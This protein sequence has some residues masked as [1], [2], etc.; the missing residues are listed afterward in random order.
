MPSSI[1]R[2]GGL[3][4]MLQYLDFF[5][6]HVQRTAL[7]ATANCC[8][9]VNTEG[10]PKVQEILPILRGVL[11]YPD[12]KLVE[13]ATLALIRCIESARYKPDWMERLLD[14]ETA[15][16]VT[17]LLAPSA[18][19][20]LLSSAVYAHLL[21]ALTSAAR[22]STKVCLSLYD[23]EIPASMYFI[24]AGVLP[25][26]HA[27]PLDATGISAAIM[28]N[29][30]ERPK[31]Q[32]E[33][34][35]A[36]ICELLPPLSKEGVFDPRNYSEKMVG[37]YSK[38]KAKLEEEHPDGGFTS[39][40]LDEAVQVGRRETAAAARDNAEAPTAGTSVPKTEGRNTSSILNGRPKSEE[41]YQQK[42]ELFNASSDKIAAFISSIM[43]TLVDVFSASA[44]AR[45]RSRVLTA[46]VKCLA[47]SS[48]EQ[49]QASLKNVSFASFLSSIISSRD[50]PSFVLG[51]LQM[52]EIL[53]DKLPVIYR[54]SFRREGVF[55]EICKLADEELS[56]KKKPEAE[57]SSKGATPQTRAEE[58]L[59][60]PLA[61][62]LGDIVNRLE[63]VRNL[64]RGGGAAG[65]SSKRTS[66]VPSNPQDAVIVRARVVRIKKDLDSIQEATD[67][68][69]TGVSI[70]SD[71]LAILKNPESDDCAGKALKDI[72]QLFLNQ[73]EPLSSFE[74]LQSGLLHGLMDYVSAQDQEGRRRKLMQALT[75]TVDSFGVTALD[76]FI[77]RLQESL[78]RMETFEVETASSGLDD[79]RRSPLTNLVRQLRIRLK[80]EDPKDI[81]RVYQD[82][83]VQVQAIAPVSAVSGYLRQKVANA[84]NVGARG[85][86]GGALSSMFAALAGGEPPAAAKASSK[87]EAP[88]KAEEK[89]KLPRRRSSAR[90]RGEPVDAES[91]AAG[92]AAPKVNADEDED[93][94]EDGGAV[95]IGEME[96]EFDEDEDFSDEEEIIY[97]GALEDDDDEEAEIDRPV[98]QTVDLSAPPDDSAKPQATTPQGTRVATPTPTG[99]AADQSR[100]NDLPPKLGSYA[101]AV[102]TAPSDWHF[103]FKVGDQVLHGYD[104]IY[105]ALHRALRSEPSRAGGLERQNIWIM[106]PTIKFS[107]VQGPEP[108]PP[109]QPTE[110]VESDAA[111][112]SALP[113]SLPAES[114]QAIVLRMLRVLHSAAKGADE[115]MFIN[116]KLTAKFIRQ[117]EEL[118]IVA[119]D[120]L[121]DWAIDLPTH[122]PF[123]FPFE[124]RYTF[125]QSTSFGYSRLIGKWLAQQNPNDNQRRSGI[126]DTLPRPTRARVRIIRPKILESASRVMELYGP[127]AGILEI[128]YQD[129]PGTGLGPTLEFYTLVSKAFAERKLELWRDEDTSAQGDYVFHPHGLFPRPLSPDQPLQ[130]P[131]KS[132]QPY[133]KTLGTFV[134][135]ALLDSRIIDL[136]FNPLLMSAML[137]HKIPL[138]IDSLKVSHL[139]G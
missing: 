17:N 5:S 3:Q 139:S 8:R 108:L 125:L 51:A 15:L 19:S 82:M 46:L 40:M 83:V 13:Q 10:F 123:L 118:V 42:M 34:A 75:E 113:P 50:D 69:S 28:Q 30:G 53:L 127:S 138:T 55:F 122:F 71:A 39:Q 31:E 68:A 64:V 23:A 29:M 61:S 26:S 63:E 18:G 114:P 116:P 89:D 45:I 2:E 27:D 104:T 132:E 57:T 1:V 99:S 107:K 72:A 77:K 6:T 56:S 105:G 66:S 65:S 95:V 88:P 12:Q 101:A 37:R 35:L 38:A 48:S 74:L 4:A 110:V 22:S 86:A 41:T 24:L 14:T 106:Q 126:L 103:Q 47:Y 25:S 16:A 120:C 91:S 54:R 98:E 90:L 93:A 79:S 21:R 76:V 58:I 43:P 96:G 32:I 128:E 111:D 44:A 135:K 33:E 131:Q 94:D 78:S 119:S 59:A 117:L 67:F 81:P 20:T 109:C 124:A 137:G 115:S 70:I 36:C 49:L 85:G 87:S 11:A 100:S 112:A 134:G 62:D 102:K 80:A 121:P 133:F 52:T 130:S 92:A 84:G 9:S 97:E 73:D 129:E 136:H 7:K 60:D